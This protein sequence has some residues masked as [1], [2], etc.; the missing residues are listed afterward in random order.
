MTGF[1]ITTHQSHIR[2]TGFAALNRC[3]STLAQHRTDPPTVIVVDNASHPKQYNNPFGY[4]YVWR[5]G[6]PN[7]LTGAWNVGAFM[8]YE[9]GCDIICVMS[10][11]I[12]FNESINYF[13]P[14][15]ENHPDK[16]NTV[17]GALTDSMTAF[18]NQIS[19]TTKPGQ[20]ID[21]TD[22]QFPIHGWMFAFTREFYSKYREGEMMF[23]TTYPFGGNE[24]HFQRRVWARGARSVLIG[25]TLVHHEHLNA[26]KKVDQL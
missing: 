6:Q 25:D 4:T 1:V 15:I 22:K 5:P 12:C 3:I 16:D 19:K 26:W 9:M 7:G 11:D 10:D 17:F 18:P 2:P 23:D 14:I 24:V 8:A 20:L 21:V 13:E